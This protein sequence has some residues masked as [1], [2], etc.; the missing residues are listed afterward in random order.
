MYADSGSR[1]V[2]TNYTTDIEDF[3]GGGDDVEMDRK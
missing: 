3:S 1:K 2:E